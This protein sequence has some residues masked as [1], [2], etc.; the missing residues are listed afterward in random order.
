IEGSHNRRLHNV[1]RRVLRLA[2]RSSRPSL[3]GSRRGRGSCRREH[4]RQNRRSRPVLLCGQQARHLRQVEPAR[5]RAGLGGKLDPHLQ[6]APLQVEL[7][8]VVFLQKL[9][10]FLQLL[11]V[12]RFHHSRLRLPVA[13]SL[14]YHSSINALAALV[15]TLFP[16]CV[17]AT[18][19]SM[20]IPNFP[21][22][23][24]PGSTVTTIPGFSSS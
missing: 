18:M 12:F 5:F 15:S 24:T 21:A 20:R 19:S 11:C 14:C 1:Q 22:R 16:R 9:N 2:R 10:E 3:G 7:A 13:F 6:V 17:T 4:L 8:Y 23:Y